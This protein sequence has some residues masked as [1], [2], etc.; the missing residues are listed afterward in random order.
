M[1]E[2]AAG[3][4]PDT[5]RVAFRVRGLTKVYGSGEAAVQALRGVD[6]DLHEGEL[7]VLLGPSG[8]GKS[9]LLNILGALDRPPRA[10]KDDI[11]AELERAVPARAE[12]HHRLREIAG[13]RG[14]GTQHE[15]CRAAAM[16]SPL[17]F[18]VKAEKAARPVRYGHAFVIYDADGDVFL[19]KR[20]AAGLLASDRSSASTDHQRMR[21]RNAPP[22]VS[23]T[24]SCA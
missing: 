14:N 19:R 13:A 7:I 21:C 16:G 20:A 2:L 8:S 4:T 11:R 22:A 18:P 1:E 15:N 24:V 5:Q 10:A 9:T 6:L 23:W 3:L 12:I 17:A